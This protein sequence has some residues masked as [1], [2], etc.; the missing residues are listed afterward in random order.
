MTIKVKVWEDEMGNI[1][2]YPV[3]E[4]IQEMVINHLNE[5]CPGTLHN[6]KFFFQEGMGAEEFKSELSSKQRNIIE[7]GWNIYIMIDP[8]EMGH[9]YGWDTHTLFE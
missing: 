5:M 6:A 9:W 2:G 8:W 4:D 3:R 7:R 1:I